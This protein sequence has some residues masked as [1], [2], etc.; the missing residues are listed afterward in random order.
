[1]LLHMI[2]TYF[3][4]SIEF[5]NPNIIYIMYCIAARYTNMTVLS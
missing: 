5:V 2:P 4:S 3:M 1:M